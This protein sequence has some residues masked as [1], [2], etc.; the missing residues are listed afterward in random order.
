MSIEITKVYGAYDMPTRGIVKKSLCTI[1]FDSSYPYG[2]EAIDTEAKNELG[3][4][5]IHGIFCEQDMGYTFKY[6]KTNGTLKV[7]SQAPPIIYEEKHTAVAN[8]VTLDYPAAWIINVAKATVTQ[9]LVNTGIAAASLGA[10]ACCLTSDIANGVRTQITTQ[11]AT[12]IIYVTYATQAWAE[13][14]GCLKQGV[15]FTAATGNNTLV[16]SDALL[17]IGYVY[18]TTATAARIDLQDPNTAAGSGRTGVTFNS[19]T[20]Q[21]NF[22]AAQNAKAME[23]MYL[24][25]PTSGFLVDR[26][27]ADENPTK[28]GADPYT[29][30]FDRPLLMWCWTG[31]MPIDNAAS[32]GFVLEH[33]TPA[34]GYVNTNWGYRGVSGTGATPAAGFVIGGKDNVTCTAGAYLYGHPWEIPGIVQLEVRDVT[35]LLSLTAVRAE[36][37]GTI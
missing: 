27:I 19:A 26:L 30:T 36:V 1:A 2:G 24:A 18:Q 31:V 37:W 12:D 22:N 13:L 16:S 29:Q 4:S 9:N 21:F 20:N 10:N 33:E 17:A 7:F 5:N 3:F 34:T 28:A 14:Y 25:K 11:G 8:L 6:D 23:I 32:K 15:T 35:N